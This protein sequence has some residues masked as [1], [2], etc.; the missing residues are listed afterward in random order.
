MKAIE[1]V[2]RRGHHTVCD[3]DTTK[4][5]GKGAAPAALIEKQ[6]KKIGK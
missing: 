3:S 4:K 6:V 1:Y 5:I 2:Y